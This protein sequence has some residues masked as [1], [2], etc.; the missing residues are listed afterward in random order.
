MNSTLGS[1]CDNTENRFF[2]GAVM[3]VSGIFAG[4]SVANAVYFARLMKSTSTSTEVSKTA[5]KVMFVFNIILC[6]IAGL[7]FL[8]ALY[9]ISF[10]GIEIK[11]TTSAP[12]NQVVNT[13]SYL[14][15]D[16]QQVIPLQGPVRGGNNTAPVLVSPT[17]MI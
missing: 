12:P 2:N 7:I 9:K 15:A 17:V 4:F 11:V 1:N 14:K 13:T 16:P 5:A 3:V 8:W 6:I 10:S